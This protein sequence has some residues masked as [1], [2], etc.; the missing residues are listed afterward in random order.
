MWGPP[1][2]GY[3][4]MRPALIGRAKRRPLSPCVRLKD[5]PDSTP[6]RARPVRSH[7]GSPV[8]ARC[9]A[10]SVS[11]A[12]HSIEAERTSPCSSLAPLPVRAALH[13]RVAA[14]LPERVRRPLPSTGKRAATAPP[15]SDELV[16]CRRLAASASSR[17]QVEPR[18]STKS[19]AS[20]HASCVAVAGVPSCYS[21]S[22][23]FLEHF[24]HASSRR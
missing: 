2:S 21:A 19:T 14:V 5:G 18:C 16:S 4:A 1:V 15:S 10:T 11:G 24:G 8:R 7:A 17:H 9:A 12:A 3:A 22:R 13:R 20:G 23:S 6:F